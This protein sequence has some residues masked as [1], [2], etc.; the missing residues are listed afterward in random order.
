MKGLSPRAFLSERPRA[1]SLFFALRSL[2]S[3]R[4]RSL[5]KPCNCGSETLCPK[6]STPKRRMA[7]PNELVAQL[8]AA[9]CDGDTARVLALLDAGAPI[10]SRVHNLTPLLTAAYRGHTD[11][12]AA[13]LGRGAL[14]DAVDGSGY[15]AVA[16]AAMM[17]HTESTSVILQA[18]ARTDI[19]IP[20]GA[21]A[22]A[23]ASTRPTSPATRP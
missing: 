17:G 20:N 9:A 19:A 11:T 3:S 6:G 22:C 16:K 7:E 18:G 4:A 12:C 23:R 21:L 1:P 15:S 5:K 8:R 13:L 14:V 10:E 2:P